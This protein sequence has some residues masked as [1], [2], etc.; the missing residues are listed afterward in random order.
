VYIVMI[1]LLALLVLVAS[2]A[3]IMAARRRRP[4]SLPDG[5][6]TVTVIKTEETP[7]GIVDVFRIDE[8]EELRGR[9]VRIVRDSK[10]WTKRS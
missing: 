5:D 3:L 7:S 1:G 8:P 2:G 9:T 10:P 6:Y 4:A